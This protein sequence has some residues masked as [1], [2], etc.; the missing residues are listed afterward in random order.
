[1]AFSTIAHLDATAAQPHSRDHVVPAYGT[2]TLRGFMERLKDREFPTGSFRER[3]KQGTN[4]M[5][6]DI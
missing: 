5:P 6:T 2:P 3:M 4:A 1:M